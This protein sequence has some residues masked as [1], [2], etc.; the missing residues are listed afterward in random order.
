MKPALLHQTDLFR[1]AI[2][3]DDHWDIA[4]VY[5]LAMAG[6]LDIAGVLLDF[7]P[8]DRYPGRSPDINAIGQLSYMSGIPMNVA[9]GA[10]RPFVADADAIRAWPAHERAGA[11]FVLTSLRRSSGKML[12]SIVGSCRDVALASVLDPGLFADKCAGIYLNAGTGAPDPEKVPRLEYN[13]ALNASAYAAIFDVRC[14]IYWMP[15]FEDEIDEF[16]IRQFGTFYKFRQD[17][18]L[19]HLSPDMR[20]YFTYSLESRTD[21]RYLQPII[22]P[23][24]DMESYYTRIAHRHMWCTGG[25][26][27]AAGKTVSSSGDIVALDAADADPV[28]RFRPISV[29]CDTTGYTRWSDAPDSRSRFIFEVLDRERYQSA[30]THAMCSLLA[31]V[32]LQGTKIGA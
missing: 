32:S 13:V 1:P 21:S 22:E 23:E 6:Q 27:H 26:F 16:R 4:C 10:S 28:F 12:I 7:P 30:M 29:S 17:E 3:P 25:F 18:I 19:P 11:E 20:A 8:I 14:P 9:V 15:C 2:D 5:A 31:S 24:R